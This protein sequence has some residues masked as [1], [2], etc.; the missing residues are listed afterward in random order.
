MIRYALSHAQLR[1]DIEREYP[2]WF[3]RAK[4]R[5]TKFI[6]QGRFDEKSSIWSEAKHAFMLQQFNKC[7]FCERVFSAPQ[8][9]RIEMDV[10]HFR[11]KGTVSG[12]EFVSPMN[13]YPVNTGLASTKGYYW[14]AYDVANYLAS[15]KICNSQHKRTYFPIAGP[16]CEHPND[17]AG[18][19]AEQAYLVYPLGTVDTDPENLITFTGTVAR[20]VVP[21]GKQHARAAVIIDLFG[22]NT[23]DQLHV[24]RAEIIERFGN[25]LIAVADG[26]AGPADH[27][28][29]AAIGD[30]IIPHA[31]CLRAFKNLWDAD[32]QGGRRLLDACR[33]M[34]A[35]VLLDPSAKG[36][37]IGFS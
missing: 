13:S 5:T 1:A 33:A 15:C 22:L 27:T 28:Y 34:L 4:T 31:A 26:R 11:P 29:V 2:T 21:N 23:R 6:E 8:E 17:P 30:P 12:W 19:A 36:L 3:T 7:A 32:Q 37:G 35:K 18:I 25:A 24:Q 9:S 20:P 10:E 16:R 14:L